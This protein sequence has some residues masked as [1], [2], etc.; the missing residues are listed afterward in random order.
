M[1]IKE[2]TIIWGRSVHIHH[3]KAIAETLPPSSCEQ[4]WRLHLATGHTVN[5]HDQF[6]FY[7]DV[8]LS[9]YSLLNSPPDLKKDCILGI[10]VPSKYVEL[11]KKL[12]PCLIEIK[13]FILWYLYCRELFC[14]SAFTEIYFSY[15]WPLLIHKHKSADP[16]RAEQKWTFLFN[17]EI[18]DAS[19]SD[20]SVRRIKKRPSLGLVSQKHVSILRT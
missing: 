6:S 17:P 16:L 13:C 4:D 7:C 9:C 8:N 1:Q 10:L 12:Q 19:W 11:R 2:R 3:V 20:V 15:M 18:S 5:D 14:I